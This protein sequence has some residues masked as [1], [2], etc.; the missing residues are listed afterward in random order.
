MIKNKKIAII[1]FAKEGVAAANYL[2]PF[3]RI[4]IFDVKEKEK[5]DPVFL[6]TLNNSKQI[7]FFLKGSA[8]K[9]HNYDLIVRSP[10]IRP[11]DK[12]IESLKSKGTIIT[13]GTKIFFDQCPAKIVGVTGTKGKGTTST[14]IYEMLKTA[15]NNVFIAGN[16][17]TPALEILPKLNGKS[18]VIL[19]LSSFQLLD[20]EKSPHVAVVLMTTTEHLDW[21]TNNAEYVQAKCNI[22]KYQTLRDFAV[23]NADYRN[24]VQIGKKSR[25][26]VFYFSTKSKA[27]GAYL[28]KDQL[29]SEIKERESIDTKS[30]LIPGAHNYQNVMAA[31]CAAQILGVSISD[32]KKVVSTFKGL[33][34]RLQLVRVVN[35]V[36]FYNDSFSTTPETAIA[37][38]NAFQNP[39]IVILGGSTKH[40]DFSELAK[41][42]V[43]GKN[44]KAII[45]IGQESGRLM[46][47]IKKSGVFQ[48]KILQGAKDMSQII[49]DAFSEAESGDVVIL[50]PA[51][52]SFDMFKNYQDRGD[53]FIVEVNKLK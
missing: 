35:N 30:I 53:Q 14:L 41:A 3:N 15:S 50:S 27:N 16:I 21:H 36:S 4:T 33:K 34:H 31:M 24:S 38:I 37:A 22:T 7:G 25:G 48:G 45:L 47:T 11:D 51:C 20:L 29:I 18:I 46:T 5:I 32:I 12:F 17:G 13:T 39:K 42:I 40:S 6:N 8:P 52:A 49:A 26:K 19:E 44:I 10:G 43:D 23:V 2:S 28:Q 1:G 9:D